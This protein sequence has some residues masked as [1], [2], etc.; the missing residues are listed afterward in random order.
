[1][2]EPIKRGDRWRHSVMVNGIRKTGTFDT[3][4]EARLWEL[5]LKTV[6]KHDPSSKLLIRRHK[7]TDACDRYIK[8]VTPTKRG[9]HQWEERRLN[10]FVSRFPGKYLDEITSDDI[11]LWRDDMIKS[12]SGSTV[13][14]YFNLYSNL[15]T[16]AAREWRWA[17]ENPFSTVRRPKENPPREAVWGW[18]QIRE[19]LREGQRRGGKYHEVTQAFHIALRTAMRLQEA[20]ASPELYDSSTKTVL[21]KKRKEDPRPIRIPLTYQGN[22]LMKTMPVFKVEA[23]EASTLFCKLK[24]E[25]GIGEL[26]FKDSRATALTL[27]SKRMD[28]KTLKRI[29]RHKDINILI[30]VYYRETAEEISSRL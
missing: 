23:N 14:R 15:F 4:K 17:K 11:S 10:S 28:V 9:A 29:S 21:I 24:R 2:A 6:A 16:V 5:E 12:V 27:M 26:E 30:D 20:L 25:L 19:V 18:R 13:N 7:L 8:S 3:K 1:M 22:R